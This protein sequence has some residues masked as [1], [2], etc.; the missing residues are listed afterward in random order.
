MQPSDSRSTELVA[1]LLQIDHT[2]SQFGRLNPTQSNLPR[3]LKMG[4][5]L[6]W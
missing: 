1:D 6:Q 5:N 4:L 3:F 2:N